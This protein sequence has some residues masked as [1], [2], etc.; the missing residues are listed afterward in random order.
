MVV[1][2]E[3][4]KQSEKESGGGVDLGFQRRGKSQS[5]AKVGWSW[6]TG[7]ESKKAKRHFAFF[8]MGWV[9]N[10]FLVMLSLKSLQDICVDLCANQ[11]DMYILSSVEKCA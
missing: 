8:F 5:C 1:G 9:M 7:E 4:H 6:G 2:K 3:T 11:L 10:L